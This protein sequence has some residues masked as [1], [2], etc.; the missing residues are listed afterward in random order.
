MESTEHLHR[1][2]EGLEDLRTIVKTMKSLSAVSIRQYEQAVEAL[3][4]YYRTVELG[5]QATLGPMA[6]PRT[7]RRRRGESPRSAVIVFGSDH[8]LCGRFNEEVSTRALERARTE[9][10]GSGWHRVLVVGALAAASLEEAAQPLEEILPAPGAASRITATVQQMLVRVDAWRSRDGVD[11]VYLFYNQ[12]RARSGYR[13]TEEKLLPVDVDRL[14]RVEEERWPSRSLPFF[15]M[16]PWRLVAALLRQYIFVSLF[17]ACAASQASEHS[18][19]LAAMQAA[20]K[21]LDE[22]LEE[23]ITTYR[24]VRQAAITTE[25]LD[26]VAGFEAVSGDGGE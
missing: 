24:R 5:L 17:R 21:N 20:E 15:T 25:L 9:L 19:R 12:P 11:N 6:R 4:H 16:D 13:T 2:I 18:S 23:V 10:A 1:Q 22:H 14:R 7:Q 8:G 3:G 26:V